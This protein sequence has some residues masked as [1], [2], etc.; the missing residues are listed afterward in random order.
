VSADTRAITLD[1]T[2]AADDEGGVED[3]M[4]R[5]RGGFEQRQAARS[6]SN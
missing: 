5:R 6:L 2:V 4:P 3:L 1:V